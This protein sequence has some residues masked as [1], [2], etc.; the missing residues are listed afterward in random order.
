MSLDETQT[1][2]ATLW[3]VALLATGLGLVLFFIWRK[4]MLTWLPAYLRQ[5]LRRSPTSH[6]GPVHILFCFVDHYEPQWQNRDNLNLERE[7]VNRW[8]QD[9]P[10]MARQFTDADGRHP[11]HT[12]FYPVEEYRAEHLD[13]LAGLCAQ[14]YG[15]IE[16]HLHHEDDT[17]ANLRS[18]LTDFANT[19]HQEH[20]ALP[21]DPQTGAVRYAFIHGNWA[22]DNSDPEGAWCGVNNELQI[23]RETGCYAD[24]TFP[25]APH[26]TQ[27]ATINSIY[28]VTDEPDKPKSHNRGT[29][30]RV[31][32]TGE[33][34]LL[35]VN[36]PLM[37]NWQNRKHVLMPRI[38]NSDIRASNP[39][40][41]S[42]ID[43]WVRAGIH[44]QGRPEWRFV[45]I[46]THGA[47]EPDMA[48]L[49]G[50][51]I[52]SMHR[53]LNERY[54]DG[55]HYVLHYVTA[56]EVYNIIKAAEAGEQGNPH[57]FRDYL[58]PRPTFSKPAH[59][60]GES[61]E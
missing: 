5:H 41:P 8:M 57:Q 35:L 24:F 39:P 31:G 16:V 51:G 54:N 34:D 42:R 18:T 58:L 20:G 21:I 55:Q 50:D 30:S 23:L 12:F 53:Y 10:A 32:A 29:H 33:G 17:A 61:G 49:L 59:A 28:Y 56:R 36:G 38:E 43:L 60:T 19:L 4:N 27:P 26:P 25:S 46:H 52:H 40:I 45:K 14:G 37:L 48:L 9:Y 7:R 11:V 3:V 1:M 47:Q 6:S 13:K 2:T 15:E 44:V 22:L